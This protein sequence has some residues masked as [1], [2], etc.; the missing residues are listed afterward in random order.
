MSFYIRKPVKVG[1][2][3]FNISKSGVGVSAGVKG[4]R[5]GSGPRG[6]YV[7]M[8]RKGL[9]YRKSLRPAGAKPENRGQKPPEVHPSSDRTLGQTQ[10]IES[11]SVEN[12]VDSSAQE[13]ISEIQ[14]KSNKI[15]LRN[16]SFIIASVLIVILII[17]E[18]PLWVIGLT[19][20]LSIGVVIIAHFRDKLSKSVVILYEFDSRLEKEYQELHDA[21]SKLENCSKVWHIPTESDVLD[22]KYHAGADKAV[23]R[24]EVNPKIGKRRPLK[25]NIKI[26]F[27]NAGKQDLVFMPERLLV[28]ESDKVGAISYMDLEIEVQETKVVESEKVPKDSEV[29][30]YTWRYVNKSGGPDKRFKDNPKIPVVRYQV[31]N[32]TSSTGL[33]ERFMTS[34]DGVGFPL[35]DAIESL[36]SNIYLKNAG[37]LTRDA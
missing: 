33:N 9:Y 5:L 14:E 31:L 19:T 2:F 17:L 7:H 16:I 12:M 28:F 36:S 27:I 1:P 32:L 23:K 26:P 35:K 22:K 24:N 37:K 3:R 18:I 21:F 6:N 8:G 4:L 30:D 34:K 20:I 29:V 11:V 25:T 15:S 10:E 13:L